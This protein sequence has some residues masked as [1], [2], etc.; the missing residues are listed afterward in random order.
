MER[1]Y[2]ASYSVGGQVL[3]CRKNVRSFCSAKAPL[4]FSANS[5]SIFDFTC[6]RRLNESL[7]NN[8][9]K[10]TMIEQPGLG[11]KSDNDRTHCL[12]VLH[13][14][15]KRISSNIKDVVCLTVCT[16]QWHKTGP[17]CSKFISLNS[18][19]KLLVK[20][21]FRVATVREKIWK[22]IFFQVREKSGN[23]VDSQGNLERTWK[24]REK[25]GNSKRNG[26]GRQS[27]E[28]LFILF[29][30]GKDVLSHEIV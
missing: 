24:V 29:K 26:Y 8:F 4:I 28:N 30:N 18:L 2:Q 14:C 27:P 6:T 1:N 13:D 5:I 19:K 21:L 22:M 20:D 7:T 9:V 11:V 3:F 23:F 10:L 15:V 17:S 25:S 16:V 12:S